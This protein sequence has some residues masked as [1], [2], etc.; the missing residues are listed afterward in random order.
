[1]FEIAMQLD[2][3]KVDFENHPLFVLDA[4]QGSVA[5]TPRGFTTDIEIRVEQSE[6]LAAWQLVS[7]RSAG[8]QTWETTKEGVQLSI[9]PDTGEVTISDSSTPPPY[10]LR[11]VATENSEP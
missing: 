3:A 5:F 6:D 2:P 1:L 8:S 11:I 4:E 10:F 9:D 7:K